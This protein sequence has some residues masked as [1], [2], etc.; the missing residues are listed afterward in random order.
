[1]FDP[2]EDIEDL[3]RRAADRF[4]LESSGP[5]WEKMSRTLDNLSTPAAGNAAA[6]KGGLRKFITD[7]SRL[8]PVGITVVAVMTGL[9]V[10]IGKKAS[11]AAH[12]VD[13][14][15][16]TRAAHQEAPARVAFG[17]GT[18]PENG[19]MAS[20]VVASGVVASGAIANGA[21]GSGSWVNGTVMNGPVASGPGGPLVG[22]A[23]AGSPATGNEAATRSAVGAATGSE[24]GAGSNET[25][26]A[27][28]Q[29]AGETILQDI[30]LTTN[31]DLP[32]TLEQV[33]MSTDRLLLNGHLRPLVQATSAGTGPVVSPL[34]A[35]G[36]F[37]AG[38][39]GAMDLSFVEGQSLSQPGSSGGILAGM[40]LTRRINL[41]TGFYISHK[42][43][44]TTG[45]QMP[46]VPLPFGSKLLNVRGHTSL[47]EIPLTLRYS[48]AGLRSGVFYA[49][50]GVAAYL[51]HSEMYNYQ[52]EWLG[53]KKDG[54]W[55]YPGK[56]PQHLLSA[57]TANI[58]Y[59]WNVGKTDML[60]TEFYGKLPLAGLGKASIPV[61][62]TG[63]SLSFLHAF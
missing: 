49:G 19:A 23:E 46:K 61:T 20:G 12:G 30:P 48:I 31:T 57:L 37:S 54:Q 50:A 55:T 51:V 18:P 41:E 11:H 40:Q 6:W 4:D 2:N 43:Y 29:T 3:Y 7:S 35:A 17:M 26:D 52:A 45:R 14:V 24:K 60:R 38:V 36:R 15:Q 8:I 33:R 59:R 39:S 56:I 25:G 53:R 1:M 28:T 10:L 42:V 34:R 58:G 16:T 13:A 22:R 32:L 47:K 21:S 9:A 44:Y 27:Y 5:D 62:S 63:L